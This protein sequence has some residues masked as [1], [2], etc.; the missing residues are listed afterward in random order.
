MRAWILFILLPSISLANV[1]IV[2][3][4]YTRIETSVG[5]EITLGQIAEFKNL[6]TSDQQHLSKIVLGDL[7]QKGESRVFTS[8]AISQIFRT[9]L[10]RSKYPKMQLKIPSQIK[11]ENKAIELTEKNIHRQLINHWRPL[12]KYCEFR[13][14]QVSIP[15][16]PDHLKNR[17]WQVVPRHELPKGA[18]SAQI[19]IK[20][21][22]QRDHIYWLSAYLT[23]LKEVPVIKRSAP[24]SYRL[25]EDDI[26]KEKREITFSSDRTPKLSELV[27]KKIRRSLRAGDILWSNLIVRDKA[28]QRGDLVK[29]IYDNSQFELSTLGEAAQNGFVGDR[30]KVKSKST[31]QTLTGVVVSKGKVR[32]E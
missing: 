24:M 30:V 13:L 18:F 10:N 6:S 31:N 5:T 27:G 29:L 2:V 14:T 3:N 7:P 4:P 21:Q 17:E 23:I 22:N 16:L 28:L 20:D 1:E 9:H 26:V 32:V 11:V 12:C 8:F 25:G 19:R 15:R